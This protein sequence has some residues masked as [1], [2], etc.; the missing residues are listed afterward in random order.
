MARIAHLLDHPGHGDS[1]VFRA[2]LAQ[3]E[4]GHNVKIFT[5]NRTGVDGP[6]SPHTNL[7]VVQCYFDSTRV[8]P[9]LSRLSAARRFLRRKTV[10]GNTA[11]ASSS[12]SVSPVVIPQWKRE[13]GLRFWHR[14]TFRA[15]KA[16]VLSFKPSIIHAHDLTMLPSG[17]QLAKNSSAKVIYDS[18]EYE[19]S[20]NLVPPGRAEAIRIAFESTAIAKADAVICVSDSIADQLMADYNI[21]RPQVILNASEHSLTGCL[22][23]EDLRLPEAARIAIYLG[24]LQPGRGLEMAIDALIDQP[25]WAR[26]IMGSAS[27]ARYAALQNRADEKK[28]GDR[29]FVRRPVPSDDVCDVISLCDVSLIPVQNTCLSYDYALPNKLFQS[30]RAGLPII[31][32][33]LTEISAFIK[34][35]QVGQVAQGFSAEDIAA[36]LSGESSRVQVDCNSFWPYSAEA[37]TLSYQKITTALLENIDLPEFERLPHMR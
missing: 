28:V 32:T 30:V 29:V 7:K 22:T 10:A 34:Y 26:L 8:I 19:R 33:P 2:A 4:A 3:C 1:R 21:P 37:V 15:L 25:G 36:A 35:H 13:L 11:M 14:A 31:A 6:K 17:I 27:E 18:H 16:D 12:P 24:S 23:R 5:L 9:V 20:R